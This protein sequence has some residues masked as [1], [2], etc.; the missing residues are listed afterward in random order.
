MCIRDSNKDAKGGR[1]NKAQAKSDSS[2]NPQSRRSK[3]TNKSN[4]KNRNNNKNKGGNPTPKNK[5]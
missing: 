5:E 1:P 3:G 2:G 4:N